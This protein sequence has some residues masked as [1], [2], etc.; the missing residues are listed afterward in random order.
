M[1]IAA[2]GVANMTAAAVVA[3]AAVACT[4]VYLLVMT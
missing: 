2:A 4:V 3:V 1:A